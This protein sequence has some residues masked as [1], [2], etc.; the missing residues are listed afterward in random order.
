M[1]SHRS[2]IGIIFILAVGIVFFLPNAETLIVRVIERAGLVMILVRGLSAYY[3]DL[4][5]LIDN[6]NHSD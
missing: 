4:V 5:R 6:G 3:S 1:R 2:F